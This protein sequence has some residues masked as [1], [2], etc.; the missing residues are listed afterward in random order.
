MAEMGKDGE[1]RLTI[2]KEELGLDEALKKL[3]GDEKLLEDFMKAQKPVKMEDLAKQQLSALESMVAS[4]ESIKN[5]TGTAIASSNL[6]DAVLNTSVTL[7][8]KLESEVT[9]V[10]GRL[11]NT[12][13]NGTDKITFSNQKLTE[14]I[15]GST[16]GLTNLLNSISKGDKSLPQVFLELKTAMTQFG[17]SLNLETI[18]TSYENIKDMFEGAFNSISNGNSN[19]TP[20]EDFIRLPGQTIQPLPQDT[21]F[22][23]TGFEQLMDRMGNQKTTPPQNIETKTTADVNLNIKID[24]PSQIDTNQLILAFNNQGLREKMIESIKDAMYNNGLT[25][26]TSSKTKLM[27]PYVG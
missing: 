25:S 4:L 13:V 10:L 27:N 20:V 3:G 23:G 22:G 14:S 21:L 19:T 11:T 26:P 18:K 6:G 1:Y 24:A 5:R 2:G 17:D 16:A 15:D 8:N 9:E 12:T 7:A